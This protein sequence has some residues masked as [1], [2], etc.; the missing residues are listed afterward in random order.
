[1]HDP[2][3][4]QLAHEIGWRMLWS[5]VC[6]VPFTAMLVWM[7]DLPDWFQYLYFPAVGVWLGVPEGIVRGSWRLG[8]LG[9]LLIAGILLVVSF[10]LDGMHS[11]FG[12]IIAF[13][14]VAF[15]AAGLL[16]GLGA[17]SLLASFFGI[18]SG[19]AGFYGIA[20][21]MQWVD[22]EYY[23]FPSNEDKAIALGAFLFA[24]L[25]PVF[26]GLAVWAGIKFSKRGPANPP[27][28][29]PASSV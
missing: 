12:G 8:L 18:I 17:R 4:G 20:Y 1:M 21:A 26:F 5:A 24:L 28:D 19:S 10:I 14:I 27:G 16:A 3:A 25:L 29:T 22:D 6:A 11:G 9:V 2:K 13:P 7:Y 23:V 15:S